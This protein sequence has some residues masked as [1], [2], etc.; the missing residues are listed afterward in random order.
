VHALSFR[1]VLVGEILTPCPSERNLRDLE[2]NL[3]FRKKEKGKPW[4]H[5]FV[6]LTKPAISF[7][8][9]K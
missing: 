2:I 5:I 4:L 7:M 6:E 1:K 9:K 8:G 3:G